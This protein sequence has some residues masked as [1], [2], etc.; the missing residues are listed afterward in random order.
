MGFNAKEELRSCINWISNWFE[1]ESGGAKGIILGISGGK[2]STVAARLCVEAIGSDK[3]YGLIM[4]NHSQSDLNDAINVCQSLNI[5]YSIVNIGDI[6]STLFLSSPVDISK[7]AAIN[8]AP[9]IRMTML[10]ALGQTMGLRVCGTGNAC[11]RFVGYSTKWGDG[12]SDFNPLANFTVSE[13]L[14]L[15]DELGIDYEL[16]HKAPADGLSGLTDEDNMG[17]TYEQI[18]NYMHGDRTKLPE[19][20]YRKITKMHQM[21]AHKISPIPCYQK[22]R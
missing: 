12:A 10:Y 21:A 14:R 3:V 5:K 4:P 13:V 8:V 6:Y 17:V 11:E 16:V 19:D 7:E 15:G 20:L 22:S 2:D 1:N 18:E 9:R